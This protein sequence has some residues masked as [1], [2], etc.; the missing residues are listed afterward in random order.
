MVCGSAVKLLVS[1]CEVVSW[2]VLRFRRLA[3]LEEVQILAQR[4]RRS[5][6]VV[7]QLP[8]H[9]DEQTN[10]RGGCQ[11]HRRDDAR[12]TSCFSHI[13]DVDVR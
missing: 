1:A 6:V 13:C 2:C 5:L 3:C 9:D 12:D 7:A 8:D 4:C 10:E 11:R